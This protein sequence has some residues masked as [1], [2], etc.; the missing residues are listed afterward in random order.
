MITQ[1]LVGRSVALDSICDE[2]T[3][4]PSMPTCACVGVLKC[5]HGTGCLGAK[6]NSQMSEIK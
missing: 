5:K 3:N 1:S 2:R 4:T 6:D